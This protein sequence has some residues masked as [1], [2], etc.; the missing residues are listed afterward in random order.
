[1]I[2]IF[3]RNPEKSHDGKII[4]LIPVSSRYPLHC[5]GNV[6][7]KTAEEALSDERVQNA[8]A[9]GGYR[10]SRFMAVP[11]VWDMYEVVFDKNNTAVSQKISS[12]F[13]G[14]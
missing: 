10:T 1:M 3:A 12:W 13:D 2:K 5:N 4:F 6:Y 14:P 11:G 7:F 9:V 8:P